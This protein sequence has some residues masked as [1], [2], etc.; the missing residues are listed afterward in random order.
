MN[1]RIALKESLSSSRFYSCPCSLTVRSFMYFFD[2]APMRTPFIIHSDPCYKKRVRGKS[3]HSY[4]YRYSTRNRYEIIHCRRL[5]RPPQLLRL[6]SC[7][8]GEA[9]YIELASLSRRFGQL[10]PHIMNNCNGRYFKQ[11]HFEISDQWHSKNAFLN[12]KIPDRGHPAG[13]L[14]HAAD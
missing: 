2:A 1:C 5:Q 14:F 11:N 9:I 3:A 6:P 4:V 8:G 7:V 10:G 13:H 12:L